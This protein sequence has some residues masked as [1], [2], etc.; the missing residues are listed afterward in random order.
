MAETLKPCPFCGGEAAV[1]SRGEHV[2]AQCT[3]CLCAGTIYEPCP[4]ISELPATIEECIGKAISAWNRRA[5]RM[6]DAVRTERPCA[7]AASGWETVFECSE[8]GEVVSWDDGYDPE[9]DLP[10]YCPRCGAKVIKE[11]E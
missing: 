2:W 7:D 9:T 1:F 5:E 3:E 4:D 10:S 8:C 11:D 6:C